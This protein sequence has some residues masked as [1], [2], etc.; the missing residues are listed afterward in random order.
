MGASRDVSR[1]LVGNPQRK[2]PLGRPRSKWED[3]IKMDL[4]E[5]GCGEHGLDLSGSGQ[6]QVAG[7][8]ECGNES[9]GS[10]KCGEFLE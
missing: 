10:I 1:F 9:S 2:R 5:V 4:Q 8:C 7:T 3:N 6:G